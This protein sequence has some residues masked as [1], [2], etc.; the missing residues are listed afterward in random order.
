[1]HLFVHVLF[2]ICFDYS[3]K[4]QNFYKTLLPPEKLDLIN[5]TDIEY[6]ITHLDCI[7]KRSILC[8]GQKES[9][10]SGQESCEPEYQHG[11]NRAHFSLIQIRFRFQ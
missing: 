1:M 9:Q 7:R 3:H 10:Q 8:F 2:K 5:Q 4:D 6:T 11:R